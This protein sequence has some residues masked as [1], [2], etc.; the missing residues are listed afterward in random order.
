VFFF[1]GVVFGV[2]A[3]FLTGP[4]PATPSELSAALPCVDVCAPP[5]LLTDVSGADAPVPVAGVE[6]EPD[7][8][9]S[10][11]VVS[12]ASDAGASDSEASDPE[13][14]EDSAEDSEPSGSA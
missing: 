14:A 7:A 12:G 3:G 2:A 4:S 5:E 6:S 10:P 9:E 1:F 13:A 8:L 11:T